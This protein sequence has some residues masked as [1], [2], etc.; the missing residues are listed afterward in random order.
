MSFVSPS[1][2]FLLA[3]LSVA[4]PAS[5]Q[6]AG[7][8]SVLPK[9]MRDRAEAAARLPPLSQAALAAH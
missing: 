6:D 9:A 1:L 4:A 5:A 7:E 2:I 3:T 8:L